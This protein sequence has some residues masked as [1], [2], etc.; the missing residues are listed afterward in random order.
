MKHILFFVFGLCLTFMACSSG[1]KLHSSVPMQGIM[2]KL[3][4]ASGNH[5]PMVG[6]PPNDPQPLK[7]TILVYE[8]TNLSQVTRMGDSPEYT[9]IHTRLVASVETDS[10]GAF[11][12]ALLP[13]AYSLFVKRDNHYYAN[14]FDSNNNISLFTV[15]K[16]KL[17]TTKITVTSRAVY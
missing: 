6:A 8:P 11:S 9:A 1:K 5:M 14:L 3:L 4:V 13:G 10:T 15:E 7:G 17:T 12:I 16:G 2:G